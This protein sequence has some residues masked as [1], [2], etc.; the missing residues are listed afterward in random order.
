MTERHDCT[1]PQGAGQD[2]N[3][4]DVGA[5]GPEPDRAYDIEYELRHFG[6]EYEN[7]RPWS[8][9][10]REVCRIAYGEISRLRSE[11]AILQ[12]SVAS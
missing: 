10:D 2:G 12:A 11:L 8:D 4:Q 7:E 9:D 6:F 5:Y 3:I 1:F